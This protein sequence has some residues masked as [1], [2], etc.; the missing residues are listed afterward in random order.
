[1]S[2]TDETLAAEFDY[3]L[4]QIFLND[5]FPTLAAYL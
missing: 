2:L 5:N 4:D 3:W 1:M